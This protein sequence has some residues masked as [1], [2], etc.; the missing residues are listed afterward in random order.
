MDPASA[1]MHSHLEKVLFDRG[2]IRDRV[3]EMG[4]EI[5]RDYARGGLSIIAVLQG[6]ALF[7]ADLIR[8]I[9]LPLQLDSISVASYHGGTESSGEVK[10]QQNYLPD[11]RD[12]DVL[13]LDDIL[14]SGRTL[15]AVSAK[16][17]VE[18]SPRS[19]R[20]AVLLSKRVE[21]DVAVEADYVGFEVGNEFVVGYGLDY[22]GHYRNLP[23]VGVLKPSYIQ[24]T[25]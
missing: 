2:Q 19:I 3:A 14:D 16:L 11:I 8:E 5:T 12:R 25:E 20:S 4:A 22:Q 24:S 21:R 13:L 9:H 6:G 23:V 7:M 15:A 17:K 18:C 10:F 1:N